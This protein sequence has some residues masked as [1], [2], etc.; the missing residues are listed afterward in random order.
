MSDVV[1]RAEFEELR[2]EIASLKEMIRSL[3]SAS[4]ANPAG[5]PE[6][7][8]YAIS[9]AIAAYFGK[10]ATIKIV[11]RADEAGDSWRTQGR[12]TVAASHHLSRTRGA[13]Q[14]G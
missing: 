3:S 1:T 11:R 9:A 10:R 7:H 2:A 13:Q 6:E 12:V 4:P 14:R 8:L 5:I